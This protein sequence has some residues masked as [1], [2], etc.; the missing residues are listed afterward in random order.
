MEATPGTTTGTGGVARNAEDRGLRTSDNVGGEEKRPWEKFDNKNY[1]GVKIK[2]LETVLKDPRQQQLLGELLEKLDGGIASQIKDNLADSSKLTPGQREFLRFGIYEFSKW[3]P[4]AEKISAMIK[5]HDVDIATRRNAELDTDVALR[6]VDRV[7]E[8][9]K[10][11]TIKLAMKD[12]VRFQELEAAYKALN[13]D[14]ATGKYQKWDNRVNNLCQRVGINIRDYDTVFDV[15]RPNREQTTRALNERMRE[16]MSKSGKV[17]DSLLW[18]I[19]MTKADRAMREALSINRQHFA[20]SSINPKTALSE[21]IGIDPADYY[22]IFKLSKEDRPETRRKLRERTRAEM[23]AFKKAVDFALGGIGKSKADSVIKKAREF[24][25]RA[26]FVEGIKKT[27][28]LPKG[29]LLERVDKNIGIITGVMAETL[30]DNPDLRHM[31]EQEAFTGTDKVMPEDTGPKT[32]QEAGAKTAEVNKEAD[33][34]ARFNKARKEFKDGDRLWNDLTG[35]ER[36]AFRDSWDPQPHHAD[37]GG[38]GFW[39]NVVMS[40]IKSFWK[41]PEQR[42]KLP[43]DNL[44]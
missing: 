11:Q 5:P 27:F 6:G 23:S 18:P 14:R 32:F 16:D 1:V 39:S 44:A 25:N 26:D 15:A 34:I 40:F 42:K 21:E 43:I 38:K 28:G 24:E 8:L 4:R 41:K 33:V 2:T 13:D 17:A 10:E 12:P 22:K 35:N 9:F 29:A 7:T 19:Q 31:L 20:F 30:S 37:T 3:L 36:A